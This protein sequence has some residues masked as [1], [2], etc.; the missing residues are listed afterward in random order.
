MATNTGYIEFNEQAEPSAPAAGKQRL[1]IDNTTHKLKRTDSSGVDVTVETPAAGDVPITDSGAYF[2]ST[3]VEGALQ[4]IGA[5]GG[6]PGPGT[7]FDYVSFTSAVTPTATSEA[8]AN[9]VVTGSAVAYDGSTAVWVEFFSESARPDTGGATRTL[10]FSLYDGSSS[11]GLL[12]GMTAGVAADT[13]KPVLLR[14]RITPSA[15]THTYSIRAHV[16][17]GTGYVGA[18]AGG[19][20]NLVPGYIRI[21]RV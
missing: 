4:E 7:E 14:R 13:G 5:A 3:D 6:A 19:S 18:G 2:T 17:A 20:G 15:A 11:I 16:S 10:V 8:T 21:T 9:T 1:Y 12:G